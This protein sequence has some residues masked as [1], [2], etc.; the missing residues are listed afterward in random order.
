MVV[1]LLYDLQTC[2]AAQG[3]LRIGASS[4][5]AVLVFLL[6]VWAD[7]FQL[8]L[9]ILSLSHRSCSLKCRFCFSRCLFMYLLI[10]Y[11]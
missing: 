9:L 6:L 11:N 3:F 2:E 10:M 8:K 5:L 7:M 1:L 4:Y